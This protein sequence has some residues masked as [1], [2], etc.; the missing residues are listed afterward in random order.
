ME[1]S[2]TSVDVNWIV[3]L[4]LAR[5]IDDG[6]RFEGMIEANSLPHNT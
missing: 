2:V 1:S 5:K 3:M 6:L 4:V